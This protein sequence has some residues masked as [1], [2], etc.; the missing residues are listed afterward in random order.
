VPMVTPQWR[1]TFAWHRGCCYK[2]YG[3]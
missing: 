3:F 1:L 2:V